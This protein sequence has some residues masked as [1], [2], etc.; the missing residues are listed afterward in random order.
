MASQ[1]SDQ[2][3]TWLAAYQLA[4]D[5]RRESGLF[6]PRQTSNLIRIEGKT[7]RRVFNGPKSYKI[8]FWASAPL[9]V[10]IM[11][12]KIADQ[13]KGSLHKYLESIIEN[14][15]PK[16]APRP[17]SRL[18]KRIM[19]EDDKQRALDATKLPRR[20]GVRKQAAV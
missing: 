12:S 1:V 8:T 15:V 3:Q 10:D 19:K 4:E 9:Y 2:E 5:S 17:V 13:F 7:K 20:N 11:R 16:V 14:T 18:E 6:K